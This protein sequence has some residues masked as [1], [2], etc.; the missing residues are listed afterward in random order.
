M[1]NETKQR[2]PGISSSVRRQVLA[3]KGAAGSGGR[4]QRQC[5]SSRLPS[6]GAAAAAGTTTAACATAATAALAWGGSLSRL[7]LGCILDEQ[8]VKV[9]CVWKQK[10]PADKRCET[11]SVAK[12]I[13][14]GLN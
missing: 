4:V 7:V 3:T 1:L 10:I 8:G 13:I 14:K 6:A 2:A 5:L 9:Q 12:K 11:Q